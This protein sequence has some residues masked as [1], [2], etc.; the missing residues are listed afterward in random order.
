MNP[1]AALSEA[2]IVVTGTGLVS[3]LG[4][5]VVTTWQRVRNGESGISR[6]TALEQEPDRHDGGQAPDLED[7]MP[8]ARECAYLR[9][10]C[11]D[12]LRDAAIEQPSAMPYAARRC[13][14]VMGTTLHGMRHAG[15]FLRTGSHESLQQFLAGTVLREAVAGWPIGGAM[16]TTCSACS[17]GLSSIALGISLL[18]ANKAD[19]VIAGGYDPISEYALAGFKSLRL[20]AD[21]PLR[22]FARD[23]QGMKLAEGY[24]VLILERAD[25]ARTRGARLRACIAGVGETCD[26][27]HLSQPH[28][29]GVGAASAMLQ[30]LDAA[31]FSPADADMIASHS[32]ATPE[33]DAAEYRAMVRALG[34]ALAGIPVVGF[35]SHVGHTLGGAGAVELILSI[36]AREDGIVPPCANI[37]REDVEFSDLDVSTTLRSKPVRVT[38]NSSF[39]FGGSNACVV[40]SDPGRNPTP[41]K[42]AARKPAV[43]AVTGIGVLLPGIVGYDQMPEHLNGDGFEPL[44]A[45]AGSI[46]DSDIAHLLNARRTRR[47]SEYVKLGLAATRLALDD[48]GV[49]DVAEFGSGCNAV[50]GTTHG[51][52]GFSERYYRQIVDEG[53][54]SA[55]TLLFAEGVPN[56]GAAHLA[57]TYGIRGSCQTII[58]TRTAGLDALAFAAMRIASGEW[59]RAIVSA[60]EE[61]TDMVVQTYTRLG[62]HA[63]G[64]QRRRHPGFF[65]GSGAVSLILES[66]ADAARRE[67]PAKAIIMNTASASADPRFRLTMRRRYREMAGSLGKVDGL[68]QSHNGTWL[69]GVESSNFSLT[70][71]AQGERRSQPAST[72]LYRYLP[73]LFSAGPLASMACVLA[74]RRLPLPVHRV[75]AGTAGMRR[76]PG[77]NGLN[78]FGV[79]AVDFFGQMS[80][81]RIGISDQAG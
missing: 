36:M 19:L 13:A 81:V 40:L 47:M 28:P 49:S 71:H 4:L 8:S 63:R 44:H 51:S 43:V 1:D 38:L 16:V 67:V 26:A 18:R 41:A 65:V 69:D 25:D 14:A 80:G 78:V 74:T 72:S 3:C 73:E 17:S 37:A 68:V 79:T 10:A 34:P 53:I 66:A 15:Q 29:E 64:T 31:G 33:N 55:N 5:D 27:H 77:H 6:L 58:G 24:G 45:D 23:R 21:S 39:G 9:R 32:T 22:P 76:T 42:A 54:E 30:A 70:E 35:K 52:C 61:F 60:A 12:A 7:E 59:A 56:A 62:L 20:V 57:M 48:A 11:R 75:E 46:A 2:E 50:L